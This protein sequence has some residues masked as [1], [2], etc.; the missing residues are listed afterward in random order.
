MIASFSTFT[1]NFSF[2]S[3]LLVEGSLDKACQLEA[4]LH[5]LAHRRI[6][7]KKEQSKVEQM[8]VTLMK[9]LQ[10][11]LYNDEDITV[12]AG[13]T[14]A[15]A[16]VDDDKEKNIETAE[17]NDLTSE[18]GS[19]SDDENSSH[20]EV[21]KG[22]T[23]IRSDTF[24]VEDENRGLGCFGRGALNRLCNNDENRCHDANNRCMKALHSASTYPPSPAI[25]QKHRLKSA[26]SIP[27]S[28]GAQEWRRRNGKMAADGIDFRTGLSGHTGLTVP[29][30]HPHDFL[31]R[32]SSM[33]TM[34]SHSGLTVSWKSLSSMWR[35]GGSPR[36]AAST[37]S[38]P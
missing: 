19:D 6:K 24:G 16:V 1:T 26:T 18:S 13:S 27:L 36:S 34:S 31:E 37:T 20:K 4:M 7:L 11:S 17:T 12:I 32:S 2:D 23:V 28:E 5:S 15:S 22:L 3:L 21:L 14:F 38:T 9:Q 25:A 10:A 30:T 29:H 33:R 35:G 8:T